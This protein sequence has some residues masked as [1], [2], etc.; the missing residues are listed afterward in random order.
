M[1][2]ILASID[3]RRLVLILTGVFVLLS[4]AMVTYMVIPQIKQY[5]AALTNHGVL[6][7]VAEGGHTLELQLQA[8]KQQVSELETQLHGDMAN[9][10]LQQMEAVIIGRLQK[11]SW[12]NGIEL[13]SVEPGLGQRIHTFNESLFHVRLVGDYHSLYQWLESIRREL[14]FVVI[15]RFEITPQRSEHDGTIRLGVNL[16]M[17]SYRAGRV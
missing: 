8:L 11:I 14:G 17:V 2:A 5:R 6:T 10:P 1:Q 16:T 3:T 13:I 9:L 7:Q 4:V 12:H 15:K